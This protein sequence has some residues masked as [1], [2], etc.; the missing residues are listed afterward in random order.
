[1]ILTQ[2]SKPIHQLI[3]I[4]K[5]ASTKPYFKGLFTLV[6]ESGQ[7]YEYSINLPIFLEKLKKI[8]D[9]LASTILTVF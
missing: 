4:F 8:E 3:L 7:F 6:D 1:M 5:Q 9:E 2:V